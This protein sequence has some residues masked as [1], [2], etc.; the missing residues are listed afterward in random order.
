VASL[1][2]FLLVVRSRFYGVG[3]SNAL[4]RSKLLILGGFVIWLVS[5][6]LDERDRSITGN[7]A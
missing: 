3:A 2:V 4:K 6:W 7:P 1:L 5:S